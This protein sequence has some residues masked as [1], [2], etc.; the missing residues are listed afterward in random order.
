MS[1]VQGLVGAQLYAQLGLWRPLR[2]VRFTVKSLRS[3]AITPTSYE[4]GVTATTGTRT[5][6][7]MARFELAGSGWRC[8]FFE[9]IRLGAR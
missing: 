4:V 9:I 2:N 3:C 6:A 1:Q 5:H 7:V 8:V